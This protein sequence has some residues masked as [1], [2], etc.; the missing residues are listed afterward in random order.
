[1]TE[2]QLKL[3]DGETIEELGPVQVHSVPRIDDFVHHPA[4]DDRVYKVTAIHHK[5]VPAPILMI[6]AKRYDYSA[7][8]AEWIG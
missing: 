1:V 2:I 8:L 7:T 3:A 4:G 5:F 6:V